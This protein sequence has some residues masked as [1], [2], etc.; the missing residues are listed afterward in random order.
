[1]DFVDVDEVPKWA[2]P[3]K[4]GIS[5]E[6]AR[7]HMK[8]HRVAVLVVTRNNAPDIARTFRRVQWI[9]DQFMEG[10][11]YVYEDNSDDGTDEMVKEWVAEDPLRRHGK[12]D[13][14]DHGRVN[15]ITKIARARQQC[16]RM[17]RDSGFNADYVVVM[18]ADLKQGF[19][20]DG[21]I[22]NFCTSN[23]GT[24]DVV[25]ASGYDADYVYQPLSWLKKLVGG[26][27]YGMYDTFAHVDIH[28][29][30]HRHV[31]NIRHDKNSSMMPVQSAFNGVTIYR[32][33]MFRDINYGEAPN[34]CEHVVIHEQML[35]K[36]ARIFI[37]KNFLVIR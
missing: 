32:G 2:A 27:H 20:E 14:P 22:N 5:V 29:D 11:G 3:D 12:C 18:D 7:E 28:G 1:S 35:S 36:G 4:D 8:R 26:Y 16:Y 31:G 19:T 15:R 24:W 23:I 13:T 9:C 30:S 6:G 37:N 34:V 10:H 33:K 21:F 25:C 17:Y